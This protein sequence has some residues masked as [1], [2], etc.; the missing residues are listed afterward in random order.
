[1]QYL[2]P[3]KLYIYGENQQQTHNLQYM[4]AIV[5]LWADSA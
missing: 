2:P 4:A 3:S 5:F 1:M